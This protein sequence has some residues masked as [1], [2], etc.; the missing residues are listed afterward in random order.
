MNDLYVK[1][2]PEQSRRSFL[3]AAA[4]SAVTAVPIVAA[5]ASPRSASAYVE[6]TDVSCSCTGC[7]GPCGGIDCE[8]QCFDLHDGGYCW[9]HCTY[10][11]GPCRFC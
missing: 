1:I 3:R 9:S 8:A 7:H 6:C 4:F 11:C 10:L 2:P 5:L